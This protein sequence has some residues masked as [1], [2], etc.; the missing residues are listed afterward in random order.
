MTRGHKCKQGDFGAEF[1]KIRAGDKVLLVLPPT[2]PGCPPAFMLGDAG[3]GE[4]CCEKQN[5]LFPVAPVICE[6]LAETT[7]LLAAGSNLCFSS[8]FGEE[9]GWC[10]YPSRASSARKAGWAS[11][12]VRAA[13]LAQLSTLL[14]VGSA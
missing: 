5:L 2:P 8:R 3:F 9:M 1:S 7:A 12:G 6:L 10:V 13:L 4:P 14:W 11:P